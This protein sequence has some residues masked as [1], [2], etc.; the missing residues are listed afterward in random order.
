MS[1]R[2]DE[3]AFKYGMIDYDKK[4]FIFMVTEM[5]K[6]NINISMISL[7]T[8][9]RY[10]RYKFGKFAREN[11]ELLELLIYSNMDKFADTFSRRYISLSSRWFGDGRD[12]R[13]MLYQDIT[14]IYVLSEDY[15]RSKKGAARL[16]DRKSVV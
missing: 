14:F 6:K 13:G 16:S 8:W 4:E 7:N 11:M 10:S 3:R 2:Y 1:K 5:L 15:L 9:N 12:I